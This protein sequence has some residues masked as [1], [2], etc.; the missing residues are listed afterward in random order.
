[1]WVKLKINIFTIG[2]CKT[3]LQSSLLCLHLKNTFEFLT[4]SNEAK[5]KKS[6]EKELK[7]N[8]VQ[9][10]REREGERE[11]ERES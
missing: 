2:I 10:E 1:L 11:R 7:R 3:E 8:Q 5:N 9:R 6:K 4:C